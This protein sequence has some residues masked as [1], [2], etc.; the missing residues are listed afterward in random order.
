MLIYVEK[1]YNCK[2]QLKKINPKDYPNEKNLK[3]CQQ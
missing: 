3:H 1:Y 2:I